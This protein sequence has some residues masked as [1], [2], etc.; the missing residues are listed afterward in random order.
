MNDINIDNELTSNDIENRNNNN[1]NNSNTMS[2]TNNEE[3]QNDRDDIYVNRSV[4]MLNMI[5][6]MLDNNSAALPNNNI[7]QANPLNDL[8]NSLSQ[9]LIENQDF[10][11]RNNNSNNSNNSAISSLLNVVNRVVNDI[12]NSP[13]NEDN[14]EEEKN[15][16]NNE[17]NI[18]ENNEENNEEN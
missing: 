4:E 5:R 11:N 13:M 15:E 2:N 7:P 3:V 8:I 12:D 14:I 16:E 10:L 1:N 9:E 17:E 18:E 6:N